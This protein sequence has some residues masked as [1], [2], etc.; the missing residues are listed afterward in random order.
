MALGPDADV[1]V[2][3]AV[4]LPLAV[5]S[6]VDDT[7]AFVVSDVAHVTVASGMVSPSISVTVAVIRVVSASDTNVSDVSDNVTA[8]TR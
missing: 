5:T 8:S 4:P 7:V 6:P 2:I 3:V 1:A